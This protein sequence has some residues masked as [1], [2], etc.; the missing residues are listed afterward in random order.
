MKYENKGEQPVSNKTRVVVYL[1][2]WVGNGP[3]R[4]EGQADQVDWEIT[5]DDR[6]ILWWDFA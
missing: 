3:A 2:G 4:W 6:D 5:G 1:R